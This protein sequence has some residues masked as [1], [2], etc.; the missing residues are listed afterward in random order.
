LPDQTKPT[1]NSAEQVVR[2]EHRRLDERFAEAA[3][4]LEE[5]VELEEAR[6]AFAA[7]AEQVDVHFE[8]EDR[9]YYA[10]IAALRP[11][12]R[13]DVEAIG[14]AHRRFR[15]QLAEIGGQLA[16]ADL[17]A[18]RRTF[19]HLSRAFEQHEAAEESLLERVDQEAVAAP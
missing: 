6:D 13:R 10:T 8:Q 15:L 19:A 7:L 14:M 17:E 11:E 3:R 1:G 12:L 4:I 9:L 5:P 16:S 18:A 2:A